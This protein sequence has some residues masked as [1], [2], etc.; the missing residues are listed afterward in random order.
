LR[1]GDWVAARQAVE[2][3]E[4]W[5]RIPAPLGWMAQARYCAE[6]LEAAWPLLTELAWLSPGRF[7]ELSARLADASL[8]TLRKKFD[9]SFE[10]VG[11]AADLAWF[12]A[13]A[14]TER[15]S[16]AR[17]LREAQPSRH[18]APERA[19]RLLLQILSLEREGRQHDLV[20]RRKAL[21]D[22]HAGL[23]AAYMKTR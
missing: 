7:A 17:L 14:L 5:R 19:T 21:R 10:G 4:S 11:Q 15:A 20:E 18:T 23:Y 9:A 8:D 13:W 16:L 2:R 3:I 22:V 6:G 12:P 1:A